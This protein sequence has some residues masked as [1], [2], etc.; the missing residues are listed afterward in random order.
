METMLIFMLS[1]ALLLLI[2]LILLVALTNTR[3]RIHGKPYSSSE[4]SDDIQKIKE[5]IL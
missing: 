5:Q 1:T 3:K 4:S 2:T